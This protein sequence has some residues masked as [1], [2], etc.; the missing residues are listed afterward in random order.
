M[1]YLNRIEAAFKAAS[2]FTE[3]IV[4]A[5]IEGNINRALEEVLRQPNDGWLSEESPDTTDRL[6][7]SRV[8]IVDPLDGTKEFLSGSREWAISIG[9]LEEGQL[10][11]G[12]V[13]NPAKQELFLG[14]RGINVTCNGLNVSMS[15][16]SDPQNARILASRSEVAAGKWKAF[17]GNLRI[18]PVGS[19]AYKL[20]LVAAGRADATWT[21]WPRHEWDVA[22]GV[23]LV[24][25]AGGIV[26]LPNGT[27][28]VFNQPEHQLPGILATN[29]FLAEKLLAVRNAGG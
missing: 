6:N 22:G 10:V 28:P 14:G 11:A 5:E 19:I 27:S 18:D 17:D 13:W 3:N 23:A 2:R 4:P 24:L 16:R 12:G 21:M 29:S 1:E 20:A 26:L 8:W 9:L 15:P 25:A 7:K